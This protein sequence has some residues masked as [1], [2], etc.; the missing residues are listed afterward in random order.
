MPHDFWSGVPLAEIG[1]AVGAALLALLAGLIAWF[2]PA[3]SLTPPQHPLQEDFEAMQ[4]RLDEINSQFKRAT[5]LLGDIRQ[6]QVTAM[7]AR[8][9]RPPSP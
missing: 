1:K 4:E 2:K 6:N 3:R 7:I 5:D 9:E 8:G